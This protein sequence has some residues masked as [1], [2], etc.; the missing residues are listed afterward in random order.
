MGEKGVELK[1]T[2]GVSRCGDRERMME[3]QAEDGHQGPLIYKSRGLEG[4]RVEDRCFRTEPKRIPMM[5]SVVALSTVDGR[6]NRSRT[7]A[8]KHEHR[9]LLLQ[10][11]V[12]HPRG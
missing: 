4:C 12:A 2:V 5:Q 6:P 3:Q 1:V 8:V 9:H 10:C 11:N 7:I